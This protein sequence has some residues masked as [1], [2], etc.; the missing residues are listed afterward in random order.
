MNSNLNSFGRFIKAAKMASFWKDGD[1]SS[2]HWNYWNPLTLLFIPFLVILIILLGGLK[3]L[4]DNHYRYGF[5][6]SRYWK[7]RLDKR[8]FF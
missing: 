1:T 2:Y 8:E 7:A 6:Y 4:F 5:G 3:E